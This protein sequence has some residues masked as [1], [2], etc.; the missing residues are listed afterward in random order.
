LLHVILDIS[1]FTLKFPD[2]SF[3]GADLRLLLSLSLGELHQ[4]LFPLRGIRAAFPAH[5]GLAMLA[6]GHQLVLF[7]LGLDILQLKMLGLTVCLPF[8]LLELP[9]PRF[10]AFCFFGELILLLAIGDELFF[11]GLDC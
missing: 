8:G 4:L 7:G 2:R 1:P 5:L 11:K 9:N 6:L 3:D 10:K